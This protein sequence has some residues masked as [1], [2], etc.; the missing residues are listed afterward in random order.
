VVVVVG[1]GVG[2]GAG[3]TLVVPLPAIEFDGADVGPCPYLLVASTVNEYFFEFFGSEKVHDILDV[4]QDK[5]A[6]CEETL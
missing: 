1:G 2:V 3:G 5:P 4:L 6:G